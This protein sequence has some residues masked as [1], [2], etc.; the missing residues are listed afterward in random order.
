MFW[1]NAVASANKYLIL[2]T[3]EVSQLEISWLNSSAALNI[4]SIL[5]TFEV[6]QEPMF[7][8]NPLAPKNINLILVTAVVSQKLISVLNEV[9]FWKSAP[10]SVTKVVHKLTLP[11]AICPAIVEL[12][13]AVYVTPLISAV[14]PTV[15]FGHLQVPFSK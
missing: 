11:L 1:L 6:S 10:I 5:V 13:T 4:S 3:L 14:S 2:V 8:L 9:L 7:W 12:S 15:A